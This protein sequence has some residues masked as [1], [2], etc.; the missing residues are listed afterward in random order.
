MIAPIFYKPFFYSN[1]DVKYV[2][3]YN[4][5]LITFEHWIPKLWSEKF[6]LRN[7]QLVFAFSMNFTALSGKKTTLL[8][9][10]LAAYKSKISSTYNVCIFSIYFFK[11][12]NSSSLILLKKLYYFLS[13]LFIFYNVFTPCYSNSLFFYCYLDKAINNF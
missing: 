13:N 10:H 9:A 1:K 7:T 12:S 3:F 11:F 4:I 8:S 5:E 2:F 6:N